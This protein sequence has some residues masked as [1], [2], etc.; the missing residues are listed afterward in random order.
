MIRPLWEAHS[1]SLGTYVY[2]RTPHKVIYGF[3]KGITDDGVL[4][5][6]DEDGVTH[7]IYSADIQITRQSE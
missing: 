6:E 3:A 2:A 7:S 1:N 4:L 5:I